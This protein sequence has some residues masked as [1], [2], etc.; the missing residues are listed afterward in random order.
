METENPLQF[1]GSVSSETQIVYSAYS[2][3]I[4]PNDTPALRAAIEYL[5]KTLML[6]QIEIP[7]P[8]CKKKIV[9][10]SDAIHAL[11][12]QTPTNLNPHIAAILTG[13]ANYFLQQSPET[14]R[15][16]AQAG[17]TNVLVNCLVIEKNPE[18]QQTIIN[19]LFC[20]IKSSVVYTQL[21]RTTDINFVEILLSMLK[22]TTVTEDSKIYL[23]FLLTVFAD[24]FVSNPKIEESIRSLKVIEEMALNLSLENSKKLRESIT[25]ILACFIKS[26]APQH[27]Q[28][29]IQILS[30]LQ[31]NEDAYKI[32][33]KNLEIT[34]PL[35][36]LL[37]SPAIQLETKAQV[38]Y[39]LDNLSAEFPSFTN[40][41]KINFLNTIC[42]HLNPGIFQD[43]YKHYQLARIVYSLTMIDRT[44]IPFYKTV[45]PLLM[46]LSKNNL[47][48]QILQQAIAAAIANTIIFVLNDQLIDIPYISEFLDLKLNENLYPTCREY[49]MLA[50]TMINSSTNAVVIQSSQG[51]SFIA[52]DTNN[53]LIVIPTLGNNSVHPTL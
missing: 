41:Q 42:M 40:E 39:L 31:E 6:H 17:V 52:K 24:D 48:I 35:L 1:K 30:T 46:E 16:L 2:L 27:Q 50:R 18:V 32:E 34:Q 53:S 4:L 14:H 49:Y 20:L 7:K 11:D 10:I 23:I 19:A 15:L 29:A 36:F 51:S 21:I 45:L 13:L 22:S 3:L 38:I 26:P 5:V 44:L 43:D 28:A 9:K 37:E 47:S 33:I 8:R 12:E 25:Y